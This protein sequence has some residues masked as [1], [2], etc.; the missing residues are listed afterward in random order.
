MATTL[1]PG[2]E[3]IVV[4]DG[5]DVACPYATIRHEKRKGYGAALKTGIRAARGE[6]VATM[7]GDGQHTFADVARLW[8]FI[9]YFPENEMVIG[10]R[11][12]KETEAKRWI[13][14]KILNTLAGFFAWKWIPDLNSGLR[15]FKRVTVLGYEPILCNEFSFTTTSTLAHLADGYMVDWLPIRVQPRKEGKSRVKIWSDGLRTL[16]LIIYVGMGCR[17]RGIRKI[18]RAI[19]VL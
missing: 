17:T 18:L 3:L 4:D 10:D 19:H 8:E 11:R 7:D 15:I 13:G 9:K 14:R 12:V 6:F 1:P 5:S 16:W 2:W